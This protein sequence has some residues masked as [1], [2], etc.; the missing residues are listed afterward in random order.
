MKIGLLTHS[1]N[2]RGGVVHVLELGRALKARGHSVVVIAPA[3]AGQ[4]LFRETPCR[5]A[6]ARLAGGG[7]VET[8]AGRG[9]VETVRQRIDTLR[10]HVGR[11]L[12]H[13]DFDVFHAHDGIGGNALAD[14]AGQG[15]IGA[16]LRTVHHVDRFD[17]PQL[18]EWE[19]RSIRAAAGV[20]C[21]SAHWCARLRE[22]WGVMASQVP[23]GVDLERFSAAP[24]PRDAAIT[25]S[26]GIQAAGPV[27]LAVGGIEARK[28]TLRLL[29]AFARARGRLP[30]LQLV[31]AGGASLL[32]H[33]ATV[34]AFHAAAVAASL[35]IGPGAP[36]VLTGPIPDTDLPALFRLADVL[37]MPSL[38]EGFGLAAL[39]ALASGTPA[40]VSRA[41][42]FT[43]HFS[44][45]DVF[46]ADPLQVESIAAALL[47]AIAARRPRAV[48]PVCRAF[49]WAASAERHE[50]LYRQMQWT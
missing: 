4:A 36:I 24:R 9:I 41:A 12:E 3:A 23:N 27:V 47:R 1:L 43:E 28:N 42:P 45:T 5:V 7:G 34:R 14:L 13:E 46:F 31:I 20:F 16:Y 38:L 37:A 50:A 6:L 35:D 29:Q 30:H 21:V 15:R 33:G 19:E 11:L 26:H 44:E 32:D 49:S 8:G 40:V 48:P 22:Q 25:R 39:E 17:E 2:P 10:A 18:Q